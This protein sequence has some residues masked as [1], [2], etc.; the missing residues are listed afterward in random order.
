M[1]A[2]RNAM[3]ATLI[4]L[5]FILDPRRAGFSAA[6]PFH[7][8]ITYI[9]AHAG[10]LHLSANL[11]ALTLTWRILARL[12]IIKETLITSVISAILA[13]FISFSPLSGGPPEAVT[14]GF[15]GVVY[16]MLAA[17]LSGVLAKRLKITDRRLFVKTYACIAAATAVQFLIPGINIAIHLASFT[18]NAIL[19]FACYKIKRSR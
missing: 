11:M 2:L 8:H 12:D 4:A 18:V 14:A 9:F 13:S 7:T 19:L 6:S 15:S 17:P 5:H 1:K 16:A 10:I 3:I